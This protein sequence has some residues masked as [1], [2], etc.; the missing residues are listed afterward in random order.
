[1]LCR[2]IAQSILRGSPHA[3]QKAS[4]QRRNPSFLQILHNR[5]HFSEKDFIYL[6]GYE[7][8][9][10]IREDENLAIGGNSYG[11]TV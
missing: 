6:K 11:T 4:I 1:M 7:N 10:R 9:F 5:R 2:F 8:S 3:P